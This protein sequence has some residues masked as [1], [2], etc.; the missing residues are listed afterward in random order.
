MEFEVLGPIRI[1]STGRAVAVTGRMQK[2][3]LGTLLANANRDVPASTLVDVLWPGETDD[4]ASKLYLHVHKLRRLLGEPDRLASGEGGYHLRVLPGELDAQRF[5]SL[6]D[7]AVASDPRR[8]AAL[9]REALALWRGEPYDGLDSP[10]LAERARR[11]TE[12]RLAAIETLCQAELAGGGPSSLVDE[13]TELI[14]RHPFRER[15]HELLMIALYRAGRRTAALAVYRAARRL[16]VEELGIEPGPEL[17]EAERRILAGLP[18][19]PAGSTA[20]AV[21]P[22]ELP[23]TVRNFVGRT[24]ELSELDDQ[25]ALS[26]RDSAPV[27]VVVG[28]AGV[29]KTATVVRWGNRVRSRFPDGQLYVDLRGY[30]P[31]QP[32]SAANVLEGFLQALG[33]EGPAIPRDLPARAAR[34]RALAARR[35]LLVVLDNA[36]TCEQ[37]RPLLPMSSSCHVVVTSRDSLAGLVARDGAN[38]IVLR[39]LPSSDARELF[40]GLAGERTDDADAIDK[41]VRQCVRLPLALRVAA[42]IFR[43]RDNISVADLAAELADEHRRLDLMDAD[44]DAH[45]AIRSVFSRSLHHLPPSSARLFVL[46]GLHP[47]HD[48][49]A[50]AFAAL[51][52]EELR[53]TRKAL[54]ALTRSHLVEEGFAGRYRTHD[55]LRAYARELA[56]EVEPAC[57]E[58]ATRR[59]FV[60]FLRTV[61]AA[62]A[63]VDPKA[64]VIDLAGLEET[65]TEAPFHTRDDALAWFAAERGNL[66]TVVRTAAEQGADDICCLLAAA[67]MRLFY[68]TKHWDDWLVTH[69]IAVTAARRSGRRVDEAYLLLGLGIAH[70]DVGGFEKAIEYFRTTAEVF[71]ELGNRHGQAWTLNNLGVTQDSMGRFAEAAASYTAALEMFQADRDL[72]GEGIA[73][74]NLGDLR[75]QQGLFDD[76][77]RHLR[78]AVALQRSTGDRT[79]LR[80]T[81]RTLGDLYR[82]KGLREQASEE[83]RHALAITRELDDRW[84]S[85][86]L[87]VQ[88]ADLSAADGRETEARDHLHEALGLCTATGDPIAEK[89]RARL[90]A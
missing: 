45:T 75:R 4:S 5:E 64:R 55:L 31:E 7:E 35:R 33:V 32:P 37:V 53:A 84:G 21:V 49:T 76:S 69:E 38:R 48:L 60:W 81:L 63:L 50:S 1:R 52:G 65:R 79:S 78:D 8:C 71:H 15:L 29:G 39:R 51:S 44:G 6:V 72:H 16:F 2:V 43:A 82:D 46:W 73:L 27:C 23:R 90:G 19:E 57:R 42:E 24:A 9:S 3:L 87:L 74:N 11:L 77:L 80:F 66:V 10:E 36:R 88:L 26:G 47:G 86:R 25:L 85:A 20:P 59:L 30:G 62:R 56:D 83:Y 89:I 61:L 41:V 17:R 28:T 68:L 67:L 12:R 13:L 34:F 40:R 18:I 58:A 22:S 14:R 70:D 54:D